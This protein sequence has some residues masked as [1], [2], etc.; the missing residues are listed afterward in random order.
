M[1]EEKIKR[2]E[3]IIRMARAWSVRR[4]CGREIGVWSEN[5]CGQRSEGTV[6]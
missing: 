2:S 1:E 3:T 5:G 4:G 6:G